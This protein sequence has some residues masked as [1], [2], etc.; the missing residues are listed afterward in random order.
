MHSPISKQVLFATVLCGLTLSSGSLLAGARVVSGQWEHTMTT[1]GEAESD[2]ATDCMTA[3]EAASI[4]GD[5][6]TGRAYYERKAHG[7]CK[8]KMFE[9]K[10]NTMS[11]VLSCGDRSIENT[12]TFRGETSEGVTISEGPDGIQ[13]MHIKSRRLGAC[14]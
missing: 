7:T 8:I 1:D 4:N 14:P 2:K 9:L 12:V 10:G 13:T 3:E 11:Y 6:K 5:S